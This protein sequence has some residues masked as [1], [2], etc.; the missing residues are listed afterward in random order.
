MMAAAVAVVVA[1]TMVVMED[2]LVMEIMEVAKE[3]MEETSDLAH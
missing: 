3:W 1:V 2:T